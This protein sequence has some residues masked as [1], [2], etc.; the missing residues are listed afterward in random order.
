MIDHR[1]DIAR[2]GERLAAAYLE[3]EGWRIL[4]RN[5]RYGKAGEI[6][7]I[8]RDDDYTVFVEVKTRMSDT[9]GAAAYAITP[10]K[11]RQLLRLARGYMYVH[12]VGELLCRFDVITVEFVRGEPVINHIRNAFT[13][14]T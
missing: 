5:F 9:F 11:Q 13:S 12:G 8:A 4:E 6:D 14:S 7:L 3:R 10:G 2:N 1:Q